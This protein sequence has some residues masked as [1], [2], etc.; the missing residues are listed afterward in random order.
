MKFKSFLITG[1]LFISYS[2][3]AQTINGTHISELE[4]PYIR[5][6]EI[7]EYVNKV[8]LK[9]DYGQKVK[10]H[11]D[12]WVRDED[13][14]FYEFNSVAHALGMMDEV[15]YDLVEIAHVNEL[16]DKFMYILKRK[17]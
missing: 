1:L 15:G 3:F 17:N 2:S 11:K 10:N 14:D 4:S 7:R 12:R 5:I 9:L 8:Q 16:N 13:G 6:F